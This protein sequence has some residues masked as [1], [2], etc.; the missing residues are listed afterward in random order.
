[1]RCAVLR[2]SKVYHSFKIN[3]YIQESSILPFTIPG[4]LS[5]PKQIKSII[6]T[7]QISLKSL[8]QF[9]HQLN[10][11]IQS[12]ILAIIIVNLIRTSSNPTSRLTSM[13]NPGALHMPFR[14]H[15]T[16]ALYIYNLKELT[17]CPSQK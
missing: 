14:R 4:P 11:T 15:Y 8:N 2:A 6:S 16:R 9:P 10:F 17:L 13:Y 7:F 1:M 12:P 5:R 3:I